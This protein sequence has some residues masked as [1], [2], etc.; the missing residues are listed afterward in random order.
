MTA[1]NHKYCGRATVRDDDLTIMELNLKA[2]PWLQLVL[3]ELQFLRNGVM[4]EVDGAGRIEY[5]EGVLDKLGATY[6]RDPS[7]EGEG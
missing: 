5:L 1:G 7:P 3:E 2:L 4:P 6:E